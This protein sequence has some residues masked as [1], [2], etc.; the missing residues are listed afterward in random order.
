M[1]DP[2]SQL[3]FDVN[4][5]EHPITLNSEKLQFPRGLVGEI[6]EFIYDAAPRPVREIALAGA[7]GFMA[8]ICGRAFNIGGSGLNQY[9]ILIADTGRGKEAIASGI[10][11]LTAALMRSSPTII[12]YEGPAQIASSQALSKW[13]SRQPCIYSIVGEFGLKL[14]QMADERAPPHPALLKADLLSL[15][16]KSD[17]GNAWGAMAYA[18]RE[19]NTAVVK[20]PSFTLIGESTP[21][22][23]FENISEDVVTDGL[24]PRFTIFTYEGDQ[25]PLNPQRQF[26]IPS[27]TLVETLGALVAQ[28]SSII[29]LQNVCNVA[30]TPAAQSAFDE[31]EEFARNSVNTRDPLTGL[32]LPTKANGVVTE[33]WNRAHVKASRLAAVCAVGVNYIHPRVGEEQARWA[34][35]LICEQTHSLIAKFSNNEIGVSTGNEAKQLKEIERVIGIYATTP[36]EQHEKYGGT[37]EMHRDRVICASNIQRRLVN[38]AAFRVPGGATRAINECLKRMLDNDEIRQVPKDQMVKQYGTCARA[39]SISNG[40]FILDALS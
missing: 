28:C 2:R 30:M 20:S 16:H 9:V 27:P 10:A 25:V 40:K 6:A 17:H 24:L 8:G 3:G 36:F 31:F 33:L 21:L 23:F 4:R 38:T 32:K 19:D 12:D 13:L 15:Y 18:K 5:P 29:Q 11:K 1:N 22:R 7:I 37:S 35:E 26:A 34:I 14:R 39:F